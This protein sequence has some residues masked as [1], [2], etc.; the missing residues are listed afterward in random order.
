M[1]LTKITIPESV[2]TIGIYAFYGCSLLD[3]V[4]YLGKYSPTCAIRAFDN[5]S[6]TRIVVPTNYV[7]ESFCRLPII[8]K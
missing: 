2:T 5:I 8:R 7:D 1:Y 3:T 4:T 6:V